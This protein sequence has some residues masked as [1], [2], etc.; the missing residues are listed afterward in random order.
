[1]RGAKANA[2]HH[3]LTRARGVQLELIKYD[4]SLKSLLYHRV[5]LTYFS[6]HCAKEFAIENL[7][8]T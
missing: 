5:G 3:W 8:V 4:L 2:W 7:Q 1:V 6:Q